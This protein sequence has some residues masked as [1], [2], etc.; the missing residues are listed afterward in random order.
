VALAQAAVAVAN[1]PDVILRTKAGR[2]VLVDPEVLAARVKS[3]AVLAVKV[4]LAVVPD[5]Q[6][7]QADPVAVDLDNAAVADARVDRRRSKAWSLM[8]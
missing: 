8:R 4:A 5:R 3:G 2:K 6:V 1:E 7:A